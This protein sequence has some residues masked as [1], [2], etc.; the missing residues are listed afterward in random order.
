MKKAGC[1]SHCIST[2]GHLLSKPSFKLQAA[3]LP[4]VDEWKCAIKMLGGQGYCRERV[5]FV[6]AAAAAAAVV[7]AGMAVLQQK[8][9]ITI[10]TAAQLREVL[11]ACGEALVSIQFESEHTVP[12]VRREAAHGLYRTLQLIAAS[13]TG[14]GGTTVSRKTPPCSL[15]V[16]YQVF[17]GI[18]TS[19]VHMLECSG[20]MT[21]AKVDAFY[22]HL[23]ATLLNSTPTQLFDQLASTGCP[24][25]AASGAA[26][27]QDSTWGKG[28]ALA[29]LKGFFQKPV[30]DKPVTVKAS[31]KGAVVA[32]TAKQ[33]AFAAAPG[34]PAQK[35]AAATAR[36]SGAGGAAGSGKGSSAATPPELLVGSN[37]LKWYC[38]P[39][40][41][42]HKVVVVS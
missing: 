31:S 9:Q 23:S 20:E 14:T 39:E 11:I 30:A 22:S 26:A 41:L 12:S 15:D 19:T 34:K 27:S 1:S 35:A 3:D 25:A 28:H 6:V 16:A 18:M 10:T 33:A 8:V 42:E 4:P 37:L 2:N 24:S 40:G 29:G 17:H 13:S 5:F 36:S 32:S 7:A 21:Q 38:S